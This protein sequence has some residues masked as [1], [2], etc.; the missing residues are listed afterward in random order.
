MEEWC[1]NDKSFVVL[2]G[3]CWRNLM[4]EFAAA[5]ARIPADRYLLVRYEDVLSDPERELRAIA[6]FIGLRW[7]HRLATA[8]A[9]FK[10]DTKRRNAFERDLTPEQLRA[11][12]D[13]MGPL[14][15]RYGY[16]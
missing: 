4:N 15:A 12:T 3:L 14:L 2:A 16:S 7:S 9:R 11:L 5:A 8:A 13:S 1:R 6:E 10:F